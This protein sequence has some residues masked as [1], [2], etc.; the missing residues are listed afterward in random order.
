MAQSPELETLRNRARILSELERHKE[1][2]KVLHQAL[3]FAPDDAD[4]LCRLC[5]AHYALGDWKQAQKFADAAVAADPQMAW[6]HA[7]RSNVLV[8]RNR[9]REAIKSAEQA[10]RLAPHHAEYLRPLFFA[11]M[12][13]QRTKDAANTAERFRAARPDR[14]SPYELLATIAHIRRQF[15]EAEE[16]LRQARALDPTSSEIQRRLAMLESRR[17]RTPETFQ[18]LYEAVRLDPTNAQALE[19]LSS[20]AFNYAGLPMQALAMSATLAITLM[21]FLLHINSGLPYFVILGLITL[22]VLP[23]LRLRPEWL[24]SWQPGVRILP[25]ELQENLI[26]MWRQRWVVYGVGFMTLTIVLLIFNIIFFFII[27]LF[28]H[29]LI[30][31]ATGRPFDAVC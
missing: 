9:G 21:G 1:A 27:G 28:I 14:A 8:V 24:L 3:A 19:N 2:I 16:L 15:P 23:V 31:R 13:C 6:G 20:L 5:H 29:I 26:R 22:P 4:L 11:Y 7:L 18:R 10:I 25:A 17:K 30:A 12:S